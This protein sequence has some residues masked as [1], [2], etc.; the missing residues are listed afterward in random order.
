MTSIEAGLDDL[1][2]R[3]ATRELT[4]DEA[5]QSMPLSMAF[6]NMSFICANVVNESQNGPLDPIYR[7]VLDFS[8][9]DDVFV[10]FN[11]DTLTACVKNKTSGRKNVLIL[12]WK[13]G[14]GNAE[15]A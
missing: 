4:H 13:Y 7:T 11:W 6:N 5:A 10:T 9:P 15:E 14:D 3:K 2:R 12:C 1:R 8:G